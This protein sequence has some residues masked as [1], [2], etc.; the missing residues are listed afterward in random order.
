MRKRFYSQLFFVQRMLLVIIIVFKTSYGVQSC[1]LQIVMMTYFSYLLSVKPYQT[2]MDAFP[3][4]L[5]EVFII[6]TMILQLCVSPWQTDNLIRYQTGQSYTAL[7]GLFFLLNFGS[8]FLRITISW[9]RK[10]RLKHRR[11]IEN[12]KRK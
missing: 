12:K 10:L 6:S 4:I 1:L 3:D 5:N 11:K 2:K 8:I 7:I 9:C